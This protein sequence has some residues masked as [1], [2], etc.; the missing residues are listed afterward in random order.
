MGQARTAQDGP[1]SPQMALK[2]S[3][4]HLPKGDFSYQGGSKSIT[5]LT[6]PSMSNSHMFSRDFGRETISTAPGPKL[7]A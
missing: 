4:E 7:R 2:D 1:K 3:Q 5:Y 6:T